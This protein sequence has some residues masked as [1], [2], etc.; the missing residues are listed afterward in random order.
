M[1]KWFEVK[2]TKTTV[3]AVEIEDNET[4]DQAAKYALDEAG[5]FDEAI[6]DGPIVG[7]ENIDRLRRHAD[8]VLDLG[9]QQ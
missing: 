1:S 7:D 9:S 3:F 2:V 6:T 8:E 5:E 4:E